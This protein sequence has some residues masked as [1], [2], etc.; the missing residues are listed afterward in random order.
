MAP[1]RIFSPEFDQSI[2]T[3]ADIGGDYYRQAALRDMIPQIK[4]RNA[5]VLNVAPDFFHFYQRA[6]TGRRC[7]CWAGVETTP[8]SQ[9]L[10][11]FGTGNTGGYQRYGHV[12]ETL[13]V[14]AESA[15]VNIVVAYDIKTRPLQ[16]RLAQGATR[17]W[18]DFTLPIQGGIPNCSLASLHA[19]TPRGTRVRSGVKLFTET[20]FTPLSTTAITQR[21]TAGA[22]Q[23]GLHVRVFMERPAVAA[24]SPRLSH[25]VIRY[26]TLEEDKIPADVPRTTERNA[27]SEFGWFEDTTSR[28]MFI[29]SRIRSVTSEDLFR[30]VNTGRTW[31]IVSVQPNA[32]GGILTSW[33]LE[34]RICL[35]SERYSSIP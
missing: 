9:C 20:S 25:I 18:I 8:S 19:V 1:V 16:F 27:T 23:G 26:Q 33:D 34:T 4:E 5:Q 22:T 24:E 3:S 17:G 30:Q 21:L 12:T 15:A 13:D 14:T 11:C 6:Y 2:P 10:V 32:P 7:S 31:K 29:D 35:L 28:S